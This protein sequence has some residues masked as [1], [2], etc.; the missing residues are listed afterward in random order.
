MEWPFEDTDA[1]MLRLGSSDR[2]KIYYRATTNAQR[3]RF[4][5]A[6]EL[7]H[8]TLPWH[9]PRANCQVQSE[10]GLMDLRHYTSEDEADVFAS[11]LLLPDR[12]LLELTRAHGDD[13]TGILQ[14]L[15]VANVS[16][17][18]A[19]RG[20][21]RTL[22]AGWA[23]VAYRGG[24]RLATPGTD[25]SL[26][27]ADAPTRLKK[28]SVAYGSAELNGYR[29]D[30]FQLAETLVPPSREDGDQRAVGDILNDALSAYAPQDVT[31]LVSVCNGKVGGSLREWAGRPAVETYSSLVYRFQ[32][33][34]HEPMLA[35]PDFRL[36]LA[37]KARDVEQNGQAK[38]R[39]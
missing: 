6:H 32:I 38:R 14:E 21:R 15:E 16:T 13:M 1:I 10:A 11:C 23:F 20:L 28:D 2:P 36:W 19:L 4:T 5:L 18:A 30:W 9:L 25:V 29:V 33:S 37:E 3:E 26:Y 22:L 12:W 24:F 31:H 27:A 17:L 8:L 7:G 39:R 35:I 34:E